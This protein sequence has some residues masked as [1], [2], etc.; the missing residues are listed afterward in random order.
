MAGTCPHCSIHIAGQLRQCPN[1]GGYCFV[2]QEVCPECNCPLPDLS[3]AS[4][5][6][7]PI[8][9][10]QASIPS[11]ESQSQ[12]A[13]QSENIAQEPLPQKPLRKKGFVRR[14]WKWGVAI[15]IFIL[16]CAGG[17]YFYMQRMEQKEQEDY[18]RLEGITNP[19]FYQEFLDDHPNSKH[20]EEIHERMLVLQKEVDDWKTLQKNISRSSIALFIQKYPNS[21]H[22]RACEDMLDSIDWQD[23]VS[24]GNEEAITDYLHR[25]PSGRYV[26]E[27]ADK[28]NALLLTKVTPEEKAMIRGTL[29]TFFSRAIAGQD[30]EAAQAAIPEVMI[31]FCGKQDANAEDIIEYAKE[32]MADDV[33]GLHYSLGRQMSVRKETLPDGNTGFAVEVSLHE[34]I[35]RSNIFM[36]SSNHYQVNALLNHEQKIVKMI[37]Y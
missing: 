20:Y 19:K 23:A 10:Q 8:S 21:I 2:S 18:E 31:N 17:Y 14:F 29:E 26:S 5:D 22:Q 28:K 35:S 30:I 32:K 4:N 9:D 16:L 33:F 11:E 24:I 34:T 7:Q 1:C 36:P 15:L 3:S 12:N 6:S 25:H 27:A 37:I 13:W